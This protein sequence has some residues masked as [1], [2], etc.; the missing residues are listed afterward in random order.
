MLCLFL[1]HK[2][3]NQ[4]CQFSRFSHVRLCDPV[5]R[6][7]PGSTVHVI[8]QA[9][10]LEWAAMQGV[11]P[12]PAT[13]PESAVA[14]GIAGGFFTTELT[15]KPQFYHSY[16]VSTFKCIPLLN[17]KAHV[18]VNDF[19]AFLDVGKCKNLGS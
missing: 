4:W 7:P 19:T 9:R 13:E 1:P 14:P 10:I 3:V 8:L 16:S 18:T 6:S 11:S 2:N 12:H 5:D 15:G 17:V